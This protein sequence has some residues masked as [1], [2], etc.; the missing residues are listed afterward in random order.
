VAS[1][2]ER[3][4]SIFLRRPDLHPGQERVQIQIDGETYTKL[5]RLVSKLQG[6]WKKD[7]TI[8]EVIIFLCQTFDRQNFKLSGKSHAERA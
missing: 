3:G 4:G 6:K 7:V 1:W 2:V 8:D 5:L